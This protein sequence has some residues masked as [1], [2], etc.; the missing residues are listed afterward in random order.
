[1]SLIVIP[2]QF[3]FNSNL[4]VGKQ[5]PDVKVL[6]QVLNEDADTEVASQ[7]AG[8]PGFETD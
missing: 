2:P 1:M 6:Q 7:G 8:S 5:N 4:S 3:I